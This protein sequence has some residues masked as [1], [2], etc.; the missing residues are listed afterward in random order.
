[1]AISDRVIR[2]GPHERPNLCRTG[3]RGGSRLLRVA[4]TCKEEQ[5]A[6][7]GWNRAGEGDGGCCREVGMATGGGKERD[8]ALRKRVFLEAGMVGSI[9]WNEFF[10]SLV[11]RCIQSSSAST[12]HQ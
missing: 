7:C 12:G 8:P 11:G 3:R 2:V 1:M 6:R 9:P 5:G 4:C 10:S